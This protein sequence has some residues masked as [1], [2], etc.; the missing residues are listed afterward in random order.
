MGLLEA[1]YRDTPAQPGLAGAEKSDAPKPP[2]PMSCRRARRR[3]SAHAQRGGIGASKCRGVGPAATNRNSDGRIRGVSARAATPEVVALTQAMSETWERFA[4]DGAATEAAASRIATGE[5]SAAVGA[6]GSLAELGSFIAAGAESLAL[7]V[8]IEAETLAAGVAVAAFAS[9]ASK[10]HSSTPTD[11]DAD[12]MRF[13][14]DGILFDSDTDSDVAPR[15]AWR[16]VLEQHPIAVAERSFLGIPFG[17]SE[18]KERY[19]L[20]VQVLGVSDELALQILENDATPLLVESEDVSEVLGRLAAISSREKALEL[21]GR[22]PALLVGGATALRKD[23]AAISTIVDVLYA[24]RIQQV[25]DEDG[26]DKWSKLREIEI[27]SCALSTFKPIVDMCQ[28]GLSRQDATAATRRLFRALVPAA[29]TKAVKILLSNVSAASDPWSYL[30]DQTKA[31]LSMAGGLA[32]RPSLR[33]ELVPYAPSILPHLPAIYTRLTILRPH[34]PGI[35]RIL[36]E[37][38]DVV[39]PH[40][41]RIMERMDEIEPHLPYILLHL[42]VLAKHCG[43]LLDHF[44]DLMPYADNKANMGRQLAAMRRCLDQPDSQAESCIVDQ[45]EQEEWE[46]PVEKAARDRS[47]LPK[48]LP[49]VDYLVPRLDVL[50]PHLPLVQPNLPHILPYIDDLLPYVTRFAPFPAASQNADKLV[51]Y[52]GWTLRV[53]LLPRVLNLPLVPRLVTGLGLILPRGPIEGVLE[54]RRR[55]YDEAESSSN[56]RG[57]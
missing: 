2:L 30:A 54:K 8:G 19:L 55:R 12:R 9:L 43:P 42:D 45:W 38:F 1:P 37:Y 28:C 34:I 47:Y 39:E 27:Y 36:D 17:F 18:V 24:G 50:A 46:T 21:V 33:E 20:F 29:P 41:D 10:F 7:F 26:R 16:L 3:A 56:A 25:L 35:V 5:A 44:D 13:S 4:A 32:A 52:L 11:I 53:P 15:K 51:G 22:S 14:L 40:L 48:L 23:G 57:E 49:Y 31:G 6:G